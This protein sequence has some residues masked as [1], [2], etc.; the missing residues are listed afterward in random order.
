MLGN[1]LLEHA[2]IVWLPTF[3]CSFCFEMG[4][5]S[6]LTDATSF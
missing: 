5:N 2:D 4:F 1:T 6:Y 3:L